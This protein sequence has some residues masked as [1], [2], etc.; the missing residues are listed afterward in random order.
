MLVGANDARL[1]NDGIQPVI[2]LRVGHLQAFLLSEGQS[3]FVNSFVRFDLRE[4][5]IVKAAAI[6]EPIAEAVEG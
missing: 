6:S 2:A 3:N 4:S 1:S 5:S